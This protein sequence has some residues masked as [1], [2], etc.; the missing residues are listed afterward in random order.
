V[1][2]LEKDLHALFLASS[3]GDI[4]LGFRSLAFR[5]L[6]NAACNSSSSTKFA[7]RSLTLGT[8]GALSIAMSSGSASSA[9]AGARLD[10]FFFFVY[11]TKKSRQ[12]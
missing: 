11:G 1:A 7:S 2:E 12:H 6:A 8:N 9:A 3:S 4:F 10:D 5:D